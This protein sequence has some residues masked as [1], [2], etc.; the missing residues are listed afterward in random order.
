MRVLLIESEPEDVVFL[1][2]VLMEIGEGRFGS[3]WVNISVLE[4]NTWKEAT[5]LL[6][7]HPVDVILLDLDLPDSQGIETFRRAQQSAQAIPVI[8]L[9]GAYEES[10]GVQLVRDGAQDFIVKKQA[11]C[12]PLAHAME[13]AVE[14]HRLLAAARAG[15][16]HD[17]LTGLFNR[18]GFLMAADRDRKLAEK[19]GCRLMVM[20]AE[21]TGAYEGQRRDLALVEAADRLRS[22]TGPSDLLG[23]IDPTR[24]GISIFESATESFD[25]VRIRVQTALRQYRLQAG[26]A[27]FSPDQPSTLDALMDEATKDLPLQARV[28]QAAK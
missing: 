3:K 17:V 5:G 10:L 21:L 6:A 27:V 26:A 23:R 28:A 13:N 1:R 16:N 12:A 25:A 4:A 14:R 15:S 22:I 8:L 11:D 18:S 20:I 7:N 2:D 19:L 9:L 24:F